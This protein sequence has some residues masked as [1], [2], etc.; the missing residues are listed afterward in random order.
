MHMAAECQTEQHN[1]V[2]AQI[3]QRWKTKG[4]SHDQQKELIKDFKPCK[5]IRQEPLVPAFYLVEGRSWS[6][7]ITHND[8]F[9]DK[10]GRCD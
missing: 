9:L 1:E 7:D 6:E 2:Q 4:A 3:R 5:D 8:T 10:R